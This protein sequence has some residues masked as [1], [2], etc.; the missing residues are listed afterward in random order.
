MRIPRLPLTY[1]AF[2]VFGLAVFLA[3]GQPPHRLWGA[4]AAAAYGCAA[5]VSLTR[6]RR[7]R[8]LAL[9]VAVAGALAVPLCWL[10]AAGQGMPEVGVVVRSAE[11][12]VSHFRPYK[13]AA[14]LGADL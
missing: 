5:L 12:L 1:A 4:C 7:R 13:S 6:L 3:S 11:L 10:A 2:S 9:A 8:E 14:Q